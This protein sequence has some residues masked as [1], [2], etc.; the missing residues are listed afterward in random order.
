MSRPYDAID[1]KQLQR[2]AD[3]CLLTYGTAFYPCSVP[4]VFIDSLHS[5]QAAIC[6]P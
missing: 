5:L 4:V 1:P 3:D 2:D 6:P